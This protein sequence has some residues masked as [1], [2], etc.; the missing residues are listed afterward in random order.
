[1]DLLEELKELR[2]TYKKLRECI[3]EVSKQETPYKIHEHRD[4]LED[5]MH[6]LIIKARRCLAETDDIP[7]ATNE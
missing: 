7:E 4:A 6:N 3:I 2:I 1:M 5:R